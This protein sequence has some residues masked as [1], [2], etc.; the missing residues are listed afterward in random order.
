MASRRY[1]PP[2]SNL[3]IP[4]TQ[5]NYVY[6]GPFFKEHGA[7]PPELIGSWGILYAPTREEAVER[8]KRDAFTTGKIWDWEKMV[9]VASVSGMRLSLPNPGTEGMGR[10]LQ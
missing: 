3:S 4:P 1:I 8:L 2:S 5:L 10:G 9:I 6:Q 7:T